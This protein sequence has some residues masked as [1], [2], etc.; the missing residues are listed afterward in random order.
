MDSNKPVCNVVKGVSYLIA[1]GWN[2]LFGYGLGVWLY[3]ILSSEIH[4]IGISI[5]SNILCISMSFLTYKLFVFKTKGRWLN[6]YLRCYIVYGGTACLGTLLLWLM[7]DG[8][9]TSIWIAQ[10]IGIAITVLI[11]YIGHKQIT[12]RL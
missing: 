10:G 11:S 1:G 3:K 5:L 12:F 4:I 6:E 2:T 8:L 7:V 9:G